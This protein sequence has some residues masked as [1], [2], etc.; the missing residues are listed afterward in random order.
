MAILEGRKEGRSEQWGSHAP[1]HPSHA[2][3]G[4]PL[5]GQ[6]A[7]AILRSSFRQSYTASAQD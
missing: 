3:S 6:G 7:R 4:N 1:G 5:R 2:I